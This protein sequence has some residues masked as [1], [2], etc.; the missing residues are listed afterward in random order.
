[1]TSFTLPYIPTNNIEASI[2]HTIGSCIVPPHINESVYKY[3]SSAKRQI[4]DYS[5]HWDNIKKYTNPYEF[6]HTPVPTYKSSIS[7]YK[8]ISRSYFKMIEIIKMYNLFKHYDKTK[9][10][11]FHLAE[12]PGGF[13]EAFVNIR[14][15]P[16]DT[17]YGITL[18]NDNS[19]VPGWRKS[20]D[21]LK[22][23]Q[24]I[25]LD[26]GADG[27]G[28]LM[29]SE[30][31]Q[32]CRNK[33]ENKI[34]IITADGGFDFS[35]DYNHQET[36]SLKLIFS[37]IAFAIAMQKIGGH[38]VLKMFDLFTKP[39]IDLLYILSCVYK[40]VTI[41]KPNTSRYANSEKYIICKNFQ[42]INRR[43]LLT[44]LID[45]HIMFEQQSTSDY[46]S[47]ILNIRLPYIFI[48]KLEEANSVFGQQQIDNI[49]I[50][51][52][53]L[54]IN[55]R[56]SRLSSLKKNNIQKCINW[57]IKYDEPYYKNMKNTNIFL[58]REETIY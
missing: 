26:Y 36:V 1:M 57:C 12:G 34:D 38:F 20:I 54:E 21:F 42:L 19:D 13:I 17:Y 40:K 6:I 33:Y 51:L 30:N 46:I 53:L 4:D 41:I 32:Y 39:S 25:I 43:P 28:D 48:N 8:P 27:T 15:N 23:N 44:K 56:Q 5:K 11:S 35:I 58:S 50:T 18:L 9:L 2:D 14:N 7:I 37:Q 24:N 10:T 49:I 29:K 45:M 3:L 31:L 55:N 47:S 16:N 22:D 52:G